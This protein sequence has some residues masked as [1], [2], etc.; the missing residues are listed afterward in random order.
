MVSTKTCNMATNTNFPAWQVASQFIDFFS[1]GVGCLGLGGI[2]LQETGKQKN[3]L[4]VKL[5][6]TAIVN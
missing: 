3:G 6:M 5:E 4:K 2:N 1:W